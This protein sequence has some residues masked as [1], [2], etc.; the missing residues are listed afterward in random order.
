MPSSSSTSSSE[1]RAEGVADWGAGA[2]AELREAMAARRSGG[3]GR[4]RWPVALLVALGV[5]AAIEVALQ[6]NCDAYID[7]VT[8]MYHEKLR[9]AQSGPPDDVLVLGDSVAVAGIRPS[10]VAEAF[11]EDVSLYNYA[12][13]GTGPTGAELVLRRYLGAHAAPRLVV[14]LYSPVG[15]GADGERIL[16]TGVLRLLF[17]PLD[18]L[19]VAWRQRR[20]DYVWHWLGTRLP[21]VRYRDSIR[22]G[23]LSLVLDAYPSLEPSAREWLGIPSHPTA[24][25]RFRWDYRERVERNRRFRERLA[26]ERGWHY[27]RE[28]ALPGEQLPPQDHFQVPGLEVLRAERIALRRVMAMCERAG[29]GGV[30]VLPP[31]VPL[32]LAE[33]LEQGPGRAQMESLWKETLAPYADAMGPD[34]LYISLPHALFSDPTHPNPAGAVRYTREILPILTRAWETVAARGQPAPR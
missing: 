32:A 24:L 19:R 27:F 22:T 3:G 6:L 20:P 14:L 9:R 25:Y 7:Q 23:L 11:P 13:P 31:P 21:T 2:G 30:L 8:L 12:M 18:A 15:L 28:R 16:Q 17:G 4:R 1:P 26:E 10:L 34:P 33:A 29:C 5:M